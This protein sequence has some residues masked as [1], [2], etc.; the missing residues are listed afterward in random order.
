MLKRL[1]VAC[2][3]VTALLASSGCQHDVVMG[4]RDPGYGSASRASFELQ[5]PMAELRIVDLGGDTVGVSGCGKQAMY[6]FIWGGPGW[7]KNSE[8]R[9]QVGV[10]TP[11]A[12]PAPVSAR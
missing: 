11:N 9:A 3:L 8:T 6:K 1:T 4:L 7:V 12:Q 2:L 10:G 5:C